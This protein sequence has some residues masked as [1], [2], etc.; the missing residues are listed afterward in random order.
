MYGEG[1]DPLQLG[2]SHSGPK[3]RETLLLALRQSLR[4]TV[5]D[6]G[7]SSVENQA[8]VNSE[9][10]QADPMLRA[11]VTSSTFPLKQQEG[12]PR[13]VFD[14]AE[15]LTRH[16]EVTAL[17]PGAPGARRHEQMGSVKVRRFSYF[18]PRRWQTLA[19]GHGMR[20]NL[21]DSFSCKLQVL[22]Y[23]ICQTLATRRL[24]RDEQIRIV[25]SHWMIPQGLSAALASRSK[26]PFVH[27]LSVHAADIYMLRGL[28]FGG[29]LARWVMA[30]TDFVFADGSD[31]R[32][33][34][35]KLLGYPSDAV[36]QPM[37]VHVDLFRSGPVLEPE[38]I[39]SADGFLL[40]FGRLTEK[41]GIPYLLRAMPRI[42]NQH[43]GLGLVVIGYGPLEQ[44]LRREAEQLGLG[45]A[46]IFAGRKSHADIGRYLRSCR[47]AVVPSIIDSNGETDGMPTVVAEAMASGTRVVGSAVDGIPDLIRH[48]KNGWLC[49]QKD[50]DDL[51]E[52]VLM[53]LADPSSSSVIRRAEETVDRL[54]WEK[55]ADRYAEKFRQLEQS[56]K[57]QTHRPLKI[58][59]DITHPAHVHFFKNPITKWQKDGHE[60]FITTRRKDITIEL[61]DRLGL[62]YDD[63]GPARSGLVGLGVELVGRTS[64]ICRRIRRIQP[65]VMAAIGGVW[66]A[67]AGRLCRVPSVV[68][69]DTENAW[70]SNLL[71]YPFC[72][73]VATPQCY[74]SWVPKSKHRT[75]PGYHELAYTHP[76]Y[77]TPDA[78]MLS[79]FGLSQD[80]PF[81]VMR[82]V[83]WGAAHDT[84]DHGFTG[85]EEAVR[86]LQP[87]GRV[88]ISSEAPL[89][90]S[91][92]P[93]RLTASPEH[94]HHLLAFARLFI[95]E[96]ATMASESA[97]LGT[98]AIFVSTSVRGYTNE[99]EREHGMTFTFSDPHNAQSQA[100]AKAVEILS[101]PNSADEWA[102]KRFRM[103]ADTIDVS[104]YVS[105]M[106][107]SCARTE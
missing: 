8:S 23:V 104:A 98:P 30:R 55:I 86:Q 28:P 21:R 29:A 35:D 54:R 3:I 107:V 11:L 15:A 73:M 47:V 14:L 99:Q 95:G 67:Q 79:K 101:N 10:R 18:L 49:K 34:L 91:L 74:E 22:P 76:N 93:L 69:Y 39:P 81:I 38:E 71:T 25:N 70:L 64:R 19:Y 32:D 6:V 94:A 37:G 24:V 75:Y 60:V 83:S 40:F 20:A 105:E 85:V 61:L 36:L 97:T 7:Y 80:E 66:I 2:S 44:E 53:A 31:V 56:R 102:E 68:F 51:T 65:D 72:T 50:V 77:F 92:E 87:F 84:R 96:S 62:E 43:P 13:F 26:E 5:V 41:K 9:T 57:P 78:Q 58:L 106:V 46:V 100:V 90:A 42:I 33:N 1:K 4:P 103:L 45:D 12:L 16:C 82:L 17:V 59:L 48:S 27:V 63:L 52:K 89:P 88:L